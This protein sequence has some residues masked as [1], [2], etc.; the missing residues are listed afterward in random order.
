M[1]ANDAWSGAD[2]GTKASPSR[3][4]QTYSEFH[5]P[6]AGDGHIRTL[7]TGSD[8]PPV[9]VVPADGL[10][11]R[12][13]ADLRKPKWRLLALLCFVPYGSYFFY[14][15]PG[16]VGTGPGYSIEAAFHANGKEYTIR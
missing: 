14:D 12:A 1:S 16:T 15:I 6:K 8:G 7:S 10:V 11:Q 9:T 3:P 4:M 5:T 2:E 13:L